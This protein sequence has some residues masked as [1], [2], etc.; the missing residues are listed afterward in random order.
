V[1]GPTPA[2][3][4]GTSMEASKMTLD[5]AARPG[6]GTHERSAMVALNADVVGYSRLVADDVEAMTATMEAYRALVEH[7]VREAAG[8]LVNFVG[9]SFMAVFGHATDAM[10]AAIAITTEIETRNAGRPGSSL[11]RFRMGLDQGPITHAGDE[12]FGDA[13]NISS[14]IQTIARPGGISV[15]ARVYRAL[16]EPALRFRPIGR[17]TLKGIPE[18]VDIYEFVDLPTE[19]SSSPGARPLALDEPTVAVL[20]IHAESVDETVRATAELGR[21]E[22][23]HRLART[24][25]LKVVDARSE[26]TEGAAQDTARYMIETGIHQAGE[27]L[28]VYATVFDVTTMNVVKSHKW[29]LKASDLFARSEQLADDV[30]R[31]V[32][33]DLIIGEPAGLYAELDDPEAIEQVYLGWYQLTTGTREGWAR[34]LELFGQVAR[35][36]PDQPFGYVLSAFA[37]WMGASS[38]WVRDPDATLRLASEQAKRGL[39]VGDPTGMAQTV[40]AAILMSQGRG[41]EALEA[42]EQAE[43]VRPTCDVTF[44]LQGSVRRYL[45]DWDQAVDLTDTAMRLTGVN[46]PWYPTVKAC[47]LFMGGRLEQAASIAEMVLEHQPNNLEALLV[48]AAAQVEMG[49]ARR[50]KATGRLVHERYPTV[51]VVAWLEANPYQSRE[52]VERW[53]A[54]LIAAGVIDV[55]E[56]GVAT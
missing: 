22:L 46:K 41:P 51:D 1:A 37:N 16:D 55:H 6:D 42:I 7:Q 25:H 44:G 24:P 19:G 5:S 27:D 13:L 32:E 56:A 14:R 11:V 48:L 36:H 30:A 15:S 8:R 10:R 26:P 17:P 52:V 12:I 45:G 3:I 31:S 43:I 35:S 18:A 38:G 28:R 21:M 9:D 2:S 4:I 34:S 33:V 50:A 54:D 53:R 40:E 49:L 39:A 47:S 20:P 29:S 23:I